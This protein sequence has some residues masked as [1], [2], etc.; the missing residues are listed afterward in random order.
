MEQNSQRVSAEV[1]EQLLS[2][3]Q[4]FIGFLEK[5]VGSRATAEDILQAAFVRS[6][7]HVGSIDDAENVVAWFYRVLRNAVIDH[8]RREASSGRA[9]EA[10]AREMEGSEVPSPDLKNEVCQCV[11]RILYDLKP[12]YRQALEVVDVED[13]SL[14]ELAARAEISANNAAVRVSRAREALRK[15][16]KLTCGVC[17]EH[18]C[19]DCR[20]KTGCGSSKKMNESCH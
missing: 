11:N 5:R 10:F 4:E 7:E 15:Q 2:R 1:L 18:G 8:Y 20:C 19:V 13:G 16:V 14:A 17:A 6:I 3:R 9:L 12:E